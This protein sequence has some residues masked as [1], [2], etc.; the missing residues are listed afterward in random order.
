[1]WTPIQLVTLSA[2]PKHPDPALQAVRDL[3]RENARRQGRVFR[4]Q[5]LVAWGLPGDTVVPMLRRNWW[6]RLHHG[7]Y[8]DAR[9]V[10]V[11][12]TSPER[13][14]LDVAASI[15]ALA[16]PAYAFGASA[17]LVCGLPRQWGPI[18]PVH[19]IRGLGLEGR[20]LSR[21]VTAR[22]RLA[23][24]RLRTHALDPSDVTVINGIPTVVP[25]LAAVSTAVECTSDW[26]VAILD[27]AAWQQPALIDD[28]RRYADELQHL[29][30]IG[31][32][33]SVIDLVRSGAQTP[34]ESHSR[35]RLMRCGLSEPQL[36]VP[37]HDDDGLI[38]YVD[39][40]FDE[41]GVIGE[42]DGIL[43]YRTGA[44]LIA[45]KHREDRLRLQRPVVR[46]GWDR[47]WSAPE[48]VARDLRRASTWRRAS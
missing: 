6:V 32:V 24:A 40:D 16:E 2:M 1:M 12:P 18:G 26:A 8:A 25:A 33:R 19:L 44:D 13:H 43:K 5:D 42:A 31:V 3:I 15:R 38:G 28:M 20:S 36:Q 17:A 14:L 4:R 21:R 34:L 11:D 9:D 41:L 30:G 35:L 29:A 7:V 27:A 48:L 46:W 10:E 22:D 37:Y 47:I 39:M 45:E 23:P